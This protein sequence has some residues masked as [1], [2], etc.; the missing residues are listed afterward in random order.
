MGDAE[1]WYLHLFICAQK[2][3][4][5]YKSCQFGILHL[6]FF[7][8]LVLEFFLNVTKPLFGPITI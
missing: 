8:V 6:F 1:M 2:V 3:I 5:T 7:D 4:I